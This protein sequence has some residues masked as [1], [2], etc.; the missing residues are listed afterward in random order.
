MKRFYKVYLWLLLSV[1]LSFSFTG[2][3]GQSTDETPTT[4]DFDTFTNRIFT[5]EVQ[6][7]TITLNFSLAN[8][9]EYGILDTT[10]TLGHYTLEEMQKDLLDAENNLAVLKSYDYKSLS[11]EQKLTYDIL[12]DVWDL[13]TTTGDLLLYHEV[14]GPTTG[15][16]A[17]LPVLLAEYNFY[18]KDDINTYLDL[19]PLIYDYFGEICAFE[20]EKSN[21]GL[22]MSDKVADNILDQCNTFIANK[23][24]NY[25]IEI[26]N[27]KIDSFKGLSAL[28]IRTYKAANKEAV[29]N[30]II[31]A[32]ELLINTLT[33]LKGTGTNDGGLSHFE[34]G[35]DYY[36]YLLRA[37][38]GSSRSVEELKEMLDTSITTNLMKLNSIMGKDPDVYDAVMNVTYSLTDPTEI[39]EYLKTAIK[40]DFPAC[41]E[42]NYSVKYVH[43]SLQEHLSPAMYLIP[44]IDNYKENIIYI[45]NN[46][47]YDL[48]Q[49][50][51]T[52]AHEGYPGHLYQ[53]VYFRDKNP[54]PIR[55]LLDFGGY[56]EGWATYVEYYSYH[57]TD[58]SPDV[59]DFLEAN[60]AANMALYCKL[61]IGINYDG[62]TL[63]ETADYLNSFGIT[64]KSTIEVLYTTMIEEPALYPQYGIG[65]LEFMKLK[66]TAMNSLKDKFEIKSFHQFLLDIGPAPF[67][68]I[69]QRMDTWM[70]KQ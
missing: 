2:C 40:K 37:N 43:E 55:N 21:A 56:S 68:I 19:L 28:E 24:D 32:Y 8:P 50:F 65:Y 11:D 44:A 26:F 30:S 69:A 27:D 39:L 47:D 51:N 25:L 18:T 35:K 58:F 41:P 34:K 49:I 48:Q 33:G 36:E 31:P 23:E 13:E 12:K 4:E 20:K 61:D 17:Q 3:A 10:A 54:S 9:K 60:M 63:S 14:L 5:S 59:A 16:Q 1:L 52:L 70:K 57:L 42:V 66:D 46:P 7:S 53:A 22:F 67:D 64:D 15:L 29:L 45:N 38:T 6:D 62:W